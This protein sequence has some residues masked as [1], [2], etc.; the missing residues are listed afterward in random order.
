MNRDCTDFSIAI[1]FLLIASRPV[2][3]HLCGPLDVSVAV[4]KEVAWRITADLTETQSDYTPQLGE[5][6]S[7]IATVTPALP[8][9]A[10]HG[11]FKFRGISVD[12]TIFIADWFYPGTGAGGTCTVRITV[13]QTDNGAATITNIIT[14]LLLIE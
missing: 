13:S 2:Q 1:L 11:N 6:D 3:A 14:P 10:H 12:E 5:T 9:K 4:G 7:S 8:F